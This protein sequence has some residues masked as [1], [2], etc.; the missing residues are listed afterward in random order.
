MI[1]PFRKVMMLSKAFT[2]AEQGPL[3]WSGFALRHPLLRYG[4]PEVTRAIVFWFWVSPLQRCRWSGASR[5]PDVTREE[6]TRLASGELEE[7]RHNFT[8]PRDMALRDAKL[9]LEQHWA[10]RCA[11]RLGFVPEAFANGQP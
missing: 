7:E 4:Q 2:P 5:L 11:K 9:W 1:R 6:Q 3:K 8:F 10:M